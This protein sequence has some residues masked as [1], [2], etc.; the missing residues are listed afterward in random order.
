M[1][2]MIIVWRCRAPAV[3]RRL[4]ETSYQKNSLLMSFE[5]APHTMGDRVLSVTMRSVGSAV[6]GTPQK[7]AWTR[8]TFEK[9]EHRRLTVSV[10]D[11][12]FCAVIFFLFVP[13]NPKVSADTQAPNDAALQDAIVAAWH[14]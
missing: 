1:L 11:T 14:Q 4:A 2:A 12:V 3:P 10:R 13:F 7:I 5:A 9:T 8:R 6:C